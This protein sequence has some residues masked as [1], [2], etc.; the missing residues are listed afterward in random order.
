MYGPNHVQAIVTKS[1]ILKVNYKKKYCLGNFFHNSAFILQ[2]TL[3]DDSI[4]SAPNF[5]FYTASWF[6]HTFTLLNLNKKNFLLK[7]FSL[8]STDHENF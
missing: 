8:I 7:I 1:K 5:L 6:T 4:D 2:F 3:V